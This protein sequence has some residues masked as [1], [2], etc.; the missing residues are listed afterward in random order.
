MSLKWSPGTVPYVSVC[1]E[2]A[3]QF[4]HLF[5]PN[6]A[7]YRKQ[8]T[9]CLTLSHVLDCQIV[10]EK[11]ICMCVCIYINMYIYTHHICTIHEF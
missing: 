4:W 11:K 10:Q 8:Y 1:Q 9:V 3:H 6:D 2:K 5:S 7:V